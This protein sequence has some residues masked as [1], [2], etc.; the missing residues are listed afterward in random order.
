MCAACVGSLTKG[1]AMSRAFRGRLREPSLALTEWIQR[2]QEEETGCQTTEGQSLCV[3][4]TKKRGLG[5]GR[6]GR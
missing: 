3:H 1:K 2:V 5:S 6:Q 4:K